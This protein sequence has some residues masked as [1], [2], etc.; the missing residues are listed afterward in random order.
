MVQPGRA[1][2]G[3]NRT[4]WVEACDKFNLGFRHTLSHIARLAR[5]RYGPRR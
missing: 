4:G 5:A 2:L 3:R 1:N